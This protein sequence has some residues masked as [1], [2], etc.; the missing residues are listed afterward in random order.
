[1]DNEFLDQGS[2]EQVNE[3]VTETSGDDMAAFNAQFEQLAVGSPPELPA[4]ED[5]SGDEHSR[6]PVED[7]GDS[8]ADDTT[9]EPPPSIDSDS[10]RLQQA[11]DMATQFGVSGDVLD[12][13][14]TPEA[15]EA[16]LYGMRAAYQQ[17]RS[18]ESNGKPK[19]VELPDLDFQLDP[20]WDERMSGALS[21]V[22]EFG[23]GVATRLSQYERNQQDLAQAY[24]NLMQQQ[25]QLV[26]YQR[27][28][29]LD[30]QVKSLDEPTRKVLS[31]SGM[32][33]Q[34]QDKL[35]FLESGYHASGQQPPSFNDLVQQSIALVAYPKLKEI[36][37]DAL[38]ERQK[39]KAKKA[40]PRPS[41]GRPSEREGPVDPSGMT[42]EFEAA[43]IAL[44]RKANS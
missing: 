27:S 33:K 26:E 22:K 25:Q 40:P 6:A 38:A 4:D 43:Q 1:M 35:R 8:A 11:R 42:A 20:E 34:I 44:A 41:S 2:N 14:K 23:G 36:E 31:E 12:A 9:S 18:P 30:A 7:D 5:K 39:A 13:L 10:L 17:P 15:V 16:Y 29:M 24:L 3:P 32:M 19:Q 37:R 21:R 28:S